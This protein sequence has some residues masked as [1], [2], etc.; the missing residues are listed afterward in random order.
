MI[1]SY[2]QKEEISDYDNRIAA[3]FWFSLSVLPSPKPGDEPTV[4]GAMGDFRTFRSQLTEN[5]PEEI[6][7]TM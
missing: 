4:H 7:E 1:C 3:H 6:R 5:N 2:L